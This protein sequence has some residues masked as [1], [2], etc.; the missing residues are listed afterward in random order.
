MRRR[1]SKDGSSVATMN[2]P[3]GNHEPIE[4]VFFRFGRSLRI[5]IVQQAQWIRS[6]VMNHTGPTMNPLASRFVATQVS[7]SLR[8][9][10][11]VHAYLLRPDRHE[12]HHGQCLHAPDSRCGTCQE[13]AYF[14]LRDPCDHRRHYEKE[15][16]PEGSPSFLLLAQPS[17]A[18]A[19]GSSVLVDLSKNRNW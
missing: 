18:G 2:P 11:V 7:G 12:R 1:A 8:I 6:F 14:L 4:L 15:G 17:S 9:R 3:R 13:A 16:D 19:S 5:W 10:N